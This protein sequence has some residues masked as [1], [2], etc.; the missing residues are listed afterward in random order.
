MWI[1]KICPVVSGT[2]YWEKKGEDLLSSARVLCHNAFLQHV[3]QIE[4]KLHDKTWGGALF[5]MYCLLCFIMWH[6]SKCM[7]L[8]GVWKESSKFMLSDLWLKSVWTWKS[9]PGSPESC[10]ASCRP[11]HAQLWASETSCMCK[12]ALLKWLQDRDFMFVVGQ[13]CCSRSGG[14]AALVLACLCCWWF[15]GAAAVIADSA[16]RVRLFS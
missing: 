13:T 6:T 4:I 1:E 16:N 14:G 11:S 10:A 8:A 2:L 7:L 12:D 15:L 9:F 5:F 3:F